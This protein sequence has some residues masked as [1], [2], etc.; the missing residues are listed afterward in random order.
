MDGPPFAEGKA[1][2]EETEGASEQFD[3]DVRAGSPHQGWFQQGE[4]GADEFFV[5]SKDLL[6][7]NFRI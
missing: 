4:M 6:P 2:G 1:R 5:P 3:M 7:V